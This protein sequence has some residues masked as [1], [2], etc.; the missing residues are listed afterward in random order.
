MTK[1]YVINF[2]DL[3]RKLNNWYCCIVFKQIYVKN[4]YN[5]TFYKQLRTYYYQN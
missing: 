4:V 1:K 3:F 5:Y 2:N